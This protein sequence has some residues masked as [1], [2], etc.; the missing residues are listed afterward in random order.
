[1][2][3]QEY[4]DA[5]ESTLT[6]IKLQCGHAYHTRCI[7]HC[8]L[9]IDRKCPH[10]NDVKDPPTTEQVHAKLRA[11]IKRVPEVKELLKEL[12]DIKEEYSKDVKELRKEIREYAKNRVTQLGLDKKRDYMLKC[13]NKLQT[14]AKRVAKRKGLKYV[15]ALK[16]TDQRYY[17]TTSFERGFFNIR[18]RHTLYRLKYPRLYVTFF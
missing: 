1:M 8:L 3:M 17:Y 13:L 6:C 11:E 2:D 18:Y 4:E 7:V 14:T 10:C 16:S 15:E 12:D 9:Q 5:R